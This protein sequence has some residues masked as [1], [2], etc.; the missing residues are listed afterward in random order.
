MTILLPFGVTSI[1]DLPYSVFE[2]LRLALVFISY[3]ELESEER[4]PKSI[5]FEPDELKKHWKAVERRRK[6]KWSAKPGDDDDDIRDQP[7]D[8]PWERNPAVDDLVR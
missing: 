6:Q 1:V 7:I 3:D 2:S 4:P 8:G 5:W